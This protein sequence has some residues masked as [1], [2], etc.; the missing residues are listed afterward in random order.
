MICYELA[1]LGTISDDDQAILTTTLAKMLA[2]F[3]L[4]LGAEVMIR[5]GASLHDRDI[6]ASTVAVYF[7]GGPHID[8]DAAETLIGASLPVIPVIGPHE[9]MAVAVPDKLRY[10]NMLRRRADDPQLEEL[11]AA[12]LECLG[13]LRKQ[14]RVFVSYRRI[15]S[16]L[17]AVQ[18]HDALASRGFD[19]FLDTHDIRPGDAFQDVLWHRLCDS[20]VMVMLDTPTYFE[21]KWTVQE[22]GRARAKEIHVLRVVWPDHRPSRFTDLAETIY[23]APGELQAQEGPITGARI[24]EIVIAVERLR[25][26]SIASRQM[27]ITGKLRADVERIGGS[28]EGI[29]AHRAI[30]IRLPDDRKIWAFPVVGIP[31]A[32]TLNDVADKAKHAAAGERPALVYD[33]VGIRGAWEAHLQWLDQQIKAVQAVKVHEAGY[34]FAAWS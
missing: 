29:G 15:E 3:D 28:I 20:D 13:L 21:S 11:A 22:L 1:I 33:S 31:T 30:A 17:A 18:L 7:G 34:I 32:E 24:D 12:M 9:D 6:Y 27:S 2:D 4:H 10:L 16:R 19:V 23:L 5:D 25:S 26:R 14:R 8:V